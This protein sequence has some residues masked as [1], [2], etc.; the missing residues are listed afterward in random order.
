MVAHEV[1]ALL[2]L[3]CKGLLLVYALR[4][5]VRSSLTRLFLA[6]LIVLSL[7]NVV[8]VVGVLH[9]NKNG[10]TD[11]T[12]K[13]GFVY[14]ATFI[15]FLAVLLHLS[16]LLSI[17]SWGSSK[18]LL[19]LLY[20]PVFVLEFLLFF[21]NQLV[22]GFRPF[23]YSVLRVPGPLY[24]LFEA[25]AVS[26]LIA[27]FSYLIYGARHS[28]I[29]MQRTRNRWWLLGLSPMILL[30]VYLVVSH[31]FGWSRL[32]ST[33]YV[34]I[35]VTILLVVTTYATY[36]YRLFEIELYIPWSRIRRRK[37]AFYGRIRTMIAEIADLQSGSVNQAIDRLAD[38]LRC[39]AALI[40]GPKPAFATVGDSERVGA[41]PV[42]TLRSIDQIV[43]A[44]E[45]AECNPKIHAVMKKHGVAAIVPFHPHSHSAASWLLLGESFSEQVYTPRDFRMV[46]QLFDKMADLFLD[47]L[48]AMRAQLAE[49]NTRIQT[50][51]FRV[52][53]AEAN[54]V[55]LEGKVET[56]TRENTRLVREQ[57][58]DSLLSLPRQQT[59]KEIDV[60]VLGRDKALLKQLRERFPQIEQFAGPDSASFRRRTSPEVLLYE[61]DI[62]TPGAQRKFS[63][64][65]VTSAQHCAVLLYGSGAAPLVFE[66]RRQL[67][68]TLIEVLPPQLSAEAIVRKVEALVRL[69][70]SLTAIPDADYPLFGASEV[71]RQAV[72]EAQR[73]AGFTGPVC[74]RGTDGNEAMAIA[75][76]MHQHAGTTGAF[77][78][79]HTA[80]LLKREAGD[81]VT[82]CAK[83]LDAL[84]NEVVGGTLVIDNLGALSNETWDQLLLKTNEF[85]NVRLLGACLSSAQSPTQLFKPLRPLVLELPNLRERRI[86]L[87]LLIHY[88][89][90]QFNVQAGTYGYLSQADIDELMATAYPDNLGALKSTVF[91]RLLAKA[92]QPVLTPALTIDESDKSL[93][94]HVAEFEMR[95]IEQTLKRCGGNKSKAA[96][97]LNMRPNTLHYKL[98]R[99]GL[100]TEK[101]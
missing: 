25:Y 82:Q 41:M 37:T 39:S 57:P 59:D 45:I 54:V 94:E 55:S 61:V 30:I 98:E 50:L 90:L 101:K 2:A 67:Q 56:L 92:K 17:D 66:H 24:Y 96:R 46:E 36:Q 14:F 13:F 85:A 69:R 81:D 70:Q 15:P 65:L 80:K 99:Y 64:L 21:T 5:P 100:I 58:G 51:E 63:E 4:A 31:H 62:A 88:Y 91:D 34:P 19:W 32:A 9:H 83:D 42:E 8:E 49:A 27:A 93:E 95:L 97:I 74:I 26:Y 29:A 44:N 10:F 3:F 6:F 87:P 78:V 47:K 73:I 75:A 71:F 7:H 12:V 38:T 22:E 72:T 40:G 84:L 43:I 23:E 18:R 89:T 1:P 35:A 28:R 60:V 52:K 16:L 68:G 20:V 77:R 79:L 48:V 76:Y 11:T 33:F 53:G 86:D